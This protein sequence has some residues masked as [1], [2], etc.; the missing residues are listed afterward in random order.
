[1]DSVRQIRVGCEFR[2]ESTA[3]IPA[4]FLVQSA[5]GGL[6]TVLRQSFETTP[7]VQQHGYTDL[8]GNAC[9]RLNLPAGT[10]AVRY[11]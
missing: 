3:E 4:V 9:Q 6:Q 10:S 5:V 8:Y 7:T 11:D 1:M 2:Y